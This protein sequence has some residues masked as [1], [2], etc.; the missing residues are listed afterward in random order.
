MTTRPLFILAISISLIFLLTRCETDVDLNAPYNS[1]PVIVSVLEYTADTQFVRINRT[2]LSQGN[3][4]VYAQVRDSVEYDPSE[5]EA[6][7]VKRRNGNKR[8]SIKLEPIVRSSRDPGVFFDTDITFWYTDNDLFTEDEI[9]D[10]GSGNQ[11][12]MTY[13]LNITARG[14]NFV[15]QTGF[16]R[17]RAG[18]ILYPQQPPSDILLQIQFYRESSMSYQNIGFRF[19]NQEPT[20]RYQGVLRLNY[21]YEKSDGSIVENQ[22]IDY[23]LGI[24]ENQASQSDGIRVYNFNAELWYAFVGNI[25]KDIPNIETVRMENLEF[26]LTGANDELNSYINVAQPISDFTPVLTA[27]SNFS[28]GA[29]GIL[30]SKTLTSTTFLLDVSS[31]DQLNDGEYAFGVSYCTKTEN[32]WP[33]STNNCP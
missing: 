1:T 26:R 18:T 6:W 17:V 11:N 12:I 19:R 16:P 4:T 20:A 2:Y 27:Y 31:V 25:V 5:V 9:D 14:E 7:L 30:G 33:G 21:D 15:A 3:A 22:T 8:D 23:Q 28:N 24:I 10:I 32:L 13:D 29:I